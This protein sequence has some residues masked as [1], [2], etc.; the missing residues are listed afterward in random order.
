MAYPLEQGC[1]HKRPL[2]V[3]ASPGRYVQGPGATNELGRELKRLGL[4]NS[5]LFIAGGTAQR[6]LAPIW[7]AELPPLGLT[8]VIEAFG[9]ECSEAEINR[10]VELAKTHT[11]TAVVGAGGGKASDTARAVANELEL[12]VVITPTLASTDSPCSALSVLYSEQGEMLS[13]RFYTRH[14][15]LVLVDTAVIAQDPKRQLVAGMGDALATWFEARTVLQSHVNNQLGGKPTT[16]GTALAKLCHDILL[17]D[18][19]GAC[20]AVDAGVPTPALE[21]IVEANNLLSGLGFE[22]GG[23]AAAHSVANGF[24]VIAGSHGMLHGEKVAMGLHTQLVLEGQPQSEI[25]EI[26]EY[27]RCMGLPTT[28]AQLGV[29]PESDDQIQKIA[30]RSVISGETIH[31]EPF[32][33]KAAAVACA[34]KAADQQGRAYL[35]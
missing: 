13:Y 31:N 7:Q 5:V 26:F 3:L 22:N 19:P 2:A 21:R 34:L 17:A 1:I 30:E 18:G 12:P 14:P 25:Q 9:G 16:S 6:R 32:E 24:S 4:A 35:N 27:C 28:L 29:N 15:Q 11:F 20:A 8:P 23:L 33:V 10:L